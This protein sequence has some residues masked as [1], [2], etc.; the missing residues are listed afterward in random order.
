MNTHPH[1]NSRGTNVWNP[2]SFRL[3]KSRRFA[4]GWIVF[5]LTV[6]Y[7]VRLFAD[8]PILPGGGGGDT[9]EVVLNSWSFADTNYWTSDLGYT[10]IS[11]ANIEVG[12]NGP[13]NS[14]LIDSP[15]N[16][17][18]V[19]NV[20]ESSGA[21]N[22]NVAGDGSV[23]F[24]FAPTSWAST[25]DTND[26]G[27]TGPGVYGRLLEVGNYTS[28][29]SYGWWGL[30]FNTN[31]NDISFSAQDASGDS[32]TYVSA[33]VTFTTNSW[34]LIALTWTSTN[35]VLY[36]DGN[37][38]TNGPGISVLPS[39]AV[40]SNGFA[41][42]SDAQTGL[43]QMHGA[44][45]SLYSYNFPLDPGSINAEYVLG[46]IFYLHESGALGNFT[47]APYS[48]GYSQIIDYV[49][50]PGYLTVIGTNTTTC[51]TSSNVWITN[52]AAFPSTNGTMA[53]TFMVTGGSSDLPYD[54]FGIGILPKPL[55]NGNWT[56]LGQAYPCE[57]NIIYGL[58]NRDVFLVLGTPTSFDG[59]GLTAAFDSLVLHINPDDPDVGGDGIANG[60]KLLAGLSLNTPVGVPTLNSTVTVPCC[61]VQ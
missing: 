33:P 15:T 5:L 1:P 55:T 9:N 36:V 58:T 7:S 43:L 50:G 10:P 12:T 11:F 29:A 6:F 21:T 14:L 48:P 59:D 30:Y 57:T 2:C 19:F 4:S 37:V 28:D 60:F 51:F 23:M 41:I 61:P 25:S 45:N 26:V 13:G 53:M 16:A 35:T 40:M 18:L 20:W 17:W 22:L 42:G 24:W 32:I 31:G 47:N 46:Q 44:I 27:A 3:S 34:H 49:S 39:L 38:L 54:V 56:W 52:V 8:V